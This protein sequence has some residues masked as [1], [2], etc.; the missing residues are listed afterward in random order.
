MAELKL[1]VME[2]LQEEAYK[3]IVRIDS[4]TMRRLGIRPGEIIEIEGER[5]TVGIVERAY[6]TDI[7][8]SLI[9]MDG[10][11]R[12]NART[13]IGETVKVRKADV[14]EAKSITI[15]PAQ[16][17]MM[18]HAA[19]HVFRRGLL[20]RAVIKG[21]ILALGGTRSRRRIMSDSP[22]QD[23]FDIFEQSFSGTF[24]FSDLRFIVVETSPK[25]PVI[26]TENTR[27]EVK[28]HAVEVKD[29]HIPE[30]SY[31]DIGG[32][33]EE[34]KKVREMVELPLKHPEIFERLGIQPPKG[35]LMYGPPGTGKTLLAKAVASESEANFILVKGPE[36]LNK[37]VGETEKGVRK[38]FE[39]ARQAAPTIICFDEID[40]L[41]SARGRGFDSG[42]TERVVNTLLAEMDGLEDLGDIIVIAT[43]NRPDLIDSALLRPGRFDRIIA[44]TVPDKESRSKIF[45]IHT[46]NM[47]LAK[48]VDLKKIVEKTKNYSGADIAGVC[49]EAGLLALRENIKSKEIKMKHFETALEKIKPSITDAALKRYKDIEEQYLKIGRGVAL[50]KPNYMG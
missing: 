30:V 9:R 33:D 35:I 49:R 32:L 25:T 29:E 11:I 13:G 50:K 42:V 43:T 28:S 17:G 5:K 15:A 27:I 37:F 34:I 48:D 16:R 39:K 31:E 23:I 22:F 46:K 6:P 18:I 40:A 1:K 14:K 36:L 2:A 4:Q 20:G 19:P 47:A 44:T 21:D 26:I 10:I 45:E 7:G 3:G 8:Q 38:I 41:A 12:R 24:G